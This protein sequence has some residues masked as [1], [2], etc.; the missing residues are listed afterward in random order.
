[1]DDQTLLALAGS[2]VFERG[3][4]YH[5]EGRV[6]LSRADAGGCRAL[7][8]GTERY[9]VSLRPTDRG[10]DWECDCPAAEDGSFCKH[11]VAAALAWRAEIGDSGGV[12]TGGTN[13]PLLNRL[14][15]L[16]REQL[17]QWLHEAAL[18]D[19]D[20][21]RRIEVRL[22]G[23]DPEAL[24]AALDAALRVRGFL[25]YRRSLDFACRLDEPIES[26][27]SLCDTDS[28]KALELTER[29]L[30]R[31]LKLLE[32][33]DDSA[34]AVQDR[35]AELGS[36]HARAAARADID[37]RRFARALHGLKQ[38]DEWDFLPLAVYWEA[39]GEPGRATYRAR[40]EKEYAALPPP[41]TGRKRSTIGEWGETYPILHRREELARCESDCDALIEVYSRDLGSGHAYGRVIDVCREYGRE[42]EAT[43]WAERGVREHPEWPGLR[44]RLAQCYLAAGL[45]DEAL[46]QMRLEF[47]ARPQE[48][49]WQDLRRISG[50]DWPGLREELLRA[51]AAREPKDSSGSPRE[52]TLRTRMLA[53]DG[54]LDSAV[55]LALQHPVHPGTL[56]AIAESAA[57]HRAADAARLMRRVVDFEL[58]PTNARGYPAIVRKVTRI[59]SL[60]ASADV[61][62]WI[63]GIRQ[64]YRAR[65]KLM[66]L[67]DEA[68]L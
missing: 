10:L 7:V 53:A 41:P 6:D 66:Q 39:L 51:L 37:Q 57:E 35:I 5:D 49:T 64:R 43:R 12:P 16:P 36:L 15:A 11:L 56:Y 31:L 28:D 33:T 42:A 22:A 27:R 17:A 40:I 47:L 18:D 60:D 46:E 19:P 8:R 4:R 61:T 65:R 38:R 59:Q 9:R 30:K 23:D 58:E 13:D 21:Y 45:P 29:T 24:R 50:E 3:L 14:N 26:L 67:M 54:D 20:L 2:R 63:D 1:M 62:Q 48:T 32:R 55:E 34:G 25:D 44:E 52:V 68:G